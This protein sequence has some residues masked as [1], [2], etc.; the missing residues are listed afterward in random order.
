MYKNEI[1]NRGVKALAGWPG[2][3]TVED[4][5]LGFNDFK[6]PGVKALLASPY[7]TRIKRLDL[8]NLLIAPQTRKGLQ[9]RFGAA[10]EV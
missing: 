9:D 3:A 5:E 7:L 10:V 1:G 4:L 2:L 6:A 8:S